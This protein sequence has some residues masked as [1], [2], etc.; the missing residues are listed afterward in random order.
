MILRDELYLQLFIVVPMIIY[1]HDSQLNDQWVFFL[2][3]SHKLYQFFLK[4]LQR[5][6]ISLNGDVHPYLLYYK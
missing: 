2:C 6:K 3:V 4:D 5:G 1:F